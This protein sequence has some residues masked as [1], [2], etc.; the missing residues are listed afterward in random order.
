MPLSDPLFQA[1]LEAFQRFKIKH[2]HLQ[3]M[4]QRISE[5]IQEHTSYHILAIYG[6]AGWENQR[7]SIRL[8]IEHE[9]LNRIPL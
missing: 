6:Q 4:D 9:Q 2:P 5:A 1:R 3:A 7:S 8:R